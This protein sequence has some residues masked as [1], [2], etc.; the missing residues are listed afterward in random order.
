MCNVLCALKVVWDAKLSGIIKL[1]KHKWGQ[2]LPRQIAV[3]RSLADR[4]GSISASPF[5][6]IITGSTAQ[7]F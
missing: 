2:S 1:K 3:I 4:I 6:D 7:W 5:A